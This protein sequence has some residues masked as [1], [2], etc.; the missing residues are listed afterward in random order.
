MAL[1]DTLE[2]SDNSN[3]MS[4]PMV[5]STSPITPESSGIHSTIAGTTPYIQRKK[6]MLGRISVSSGGHPVGNLFMADI[7][8]DDSD[9]P[10]VL[11]VVITDSG[12]TAVATPSPNKTVSPSDALDM[13]IR[14]GGR[15]ARL[16]Q[17][18]GMAS[19]MTT[20]STPKRHRDQWKAKWSDT[21]RHS[22]E[23]FKKAKR[24]RSG[25]GLSR[26]DYSGSVS[27]FQD[28]ASNH[29]G[30]ASAS[31]SGASGVSGTSE[32]SGTSGASGAGSVTGDAN[33]D[34]GVDFT[35]FT[36]T[37]SYKDM[38]TASEGTPRACHSDH[39]GSMDDDGDG[40]AAELTSSYERLFEKESLRTKF[41]KVFK[42]E[43]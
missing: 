43:V 34:L 20:A 3:G 35:D 12:S 30:D 4:P 37:Y 16:Y 7:W 39:F 2:S 18:V 19:G 28:G 38:V 8:Q 29:T 42:K 14:H 23:F 31:I 5:N 36:G 41:W 27:S 21:K 24:G 15:D 6:P 26:S 22:K 33:G 32:T 9:S 25:D 13:M 10:S 17:D 40:G 1:F 11:N